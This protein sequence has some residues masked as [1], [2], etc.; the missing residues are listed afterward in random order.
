MSITFGQRK[1]DAPPA[2]SNGN[3][4]RNFQK[5]E[6]TLRFLED[7]EDWIQYKEHYKNK[8]SFPCTGDTL[9][10]PGCTSD[11]EEVATRKTKYAANAWNVKAA[12]VEPYR[13]PVS[14]ANRLETRAERN[15]G[16]LGNRDYVIIKTGAGLDTEYDCDPED[17]YEAP[18][19]QYRKDAADIQVILRESYEEVWGALDSSGSEDDQDEP[20]RKS[21]MK[22]KA[23]EELPFKKEAEKAQNS[24]DTEID[25]ATVRA[26][27][28]RELRTLAKD[29]DVD[30]S[31]AEGKSEIADTI[32][33]A[34]S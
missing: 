31:D 14:L 5:G 10:C 6:T 11:D 28:L 22:P 17:K 34:L 12:R 29:A 25:E 1:A 13:I 7:P 15:D 19:A 33:D 3:W 9:A 30:I 32:I 2:A 21:K 16:T 20:A 8:R 26:M 24:V 4:L 27:T 18:L 23:E